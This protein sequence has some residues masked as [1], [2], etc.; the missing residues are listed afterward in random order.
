MGWRSKCRI[1]LEPAPSRHGASPPRCR[2]I[3]QPF[4]R[5]VRRVEV[6]G[7]VAATSK[8]GTLI[9]EDV[10]R[11]EYVAL[12]RLA[13]AICGDAAVA[14][15]VTQDAFAAAL[16]RW[17]ELV[18]PGAFLHRG[19]VNGAID[20]RRRGGRIR[21]VPL[22]ES[23]TS[24]M[25]ETDAGPPDPLWDVIDELPDRHRAVVTLRY[26]ADM[27]LADIAAVLQRPVNT[28]KSD[29]R[30]ALATLSRKVPK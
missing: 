28:I 17:D 30:R 3:L 20:V 16:L 11:R 4:E 1:V 12:V 29:L 2:P 19:V 15:E 10:F 26:F 13:T 27:P 7:P 23:L 5:S 8:S 14:E 9:F 22:R 24:G 25:E 6:Q 21:M 18:S